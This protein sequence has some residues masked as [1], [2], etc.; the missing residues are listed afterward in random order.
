MFP[1]CD[2]ILWKT[3]I[4]PVPLIQGMD[5]EPVPQI[6]RS[7]VSDFFSYHR[8]RSPSSQ[9]IRD[10]NTPTTTLSGDK[11]KA[12]PEQLSFPVHHNQNGMSSAGIPVKHSDSLPR[13]A[14][15]TFSPPPTAPLPLE[16]PHRRA[17]AFDTIVSPLSPD[18]PQ[19]ATGSIWRFLPA[20]L[21]PSHNQDSAASLDQSPSLFPL[22]L[23]GDVTCLDYNTLDDRAM[24]RLEGRSD[25]R[26]VIG[27]Y[28]VYV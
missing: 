14:H 19:S 25:H 5:D 12:T 18:R 13:R 23:K 21:S 28:V 27:T 1:R 4:K 7:R 3:T 16:Y 15:T 11:T 8:F 24:R 6:S 22:P 17:T 9:T 26:P 10:S 2:R 20:F